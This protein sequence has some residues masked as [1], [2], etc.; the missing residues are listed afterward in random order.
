MNFLFTH[1]QQKKTHHIVHIQQTILKKSADYNG[2][3]I[4]LLI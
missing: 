1:L 3:V 2:F 4:T